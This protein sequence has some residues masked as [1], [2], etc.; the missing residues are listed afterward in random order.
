MTNSMHMT[1]HVEEE[2]LFSNG[3]LA[4]ALIYLAIMA[5]LTLCLVYGGQW[6]GR[7]INL[8]GHTDS[9][10]PVMVEIGRDRLSLPQNVIRFETQRRNGTAPRV[11]LYLNWPS[12]EGYTRDQSASFNDLSKS[13]SLI[14]LQVTQSVMSRDMSGRVKPIYSHYIKGEP[15]P[16]GNGLMIHRFA[17]EAGYQEDVL[18]TASREGQD[19]Y[20]VRCI[21]PG[22]EAGATAGDC[23]RDVFIGQDLSVLYRFSSNLLPEW[24]ALD[25]A[26][27]GYMRGRLSQLPAAHR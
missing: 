4:K 12:M 11:D 6:L 21:L 20:A 7:K 25:A 14:F 26:V 8:A 2:P 5:T 9:R 24:R 27:T 23:Q 18:L 3:F 1:G 15:V 22:P 17:P 10:E 13:R 16:Y 19:D